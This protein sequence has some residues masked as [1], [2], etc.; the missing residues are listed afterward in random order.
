MKK[1]MCLFYLL[2]SINSLYAI[3]VAI[4]DAENAVYFTLDSNWVEAL[5][6]NQVAIVK[7]TQSFTN[8][9]T[10]EH[11]SIYAFP[12]PEGASAT[13]LRW[14]YNNQWNQATINPIPDTGQGMPSNPNSNLVAYL[15]ET[16]LYFNIPDTVA[17]DSTIIV[18]LTYVELL[19]Y[20]WGNVDLIIPN[21]YQLIQTGQV[22]LQ[23][24]DFQLNSLRYIDSLKLLSNHP[25]SSLVNNGYYASLFS[26][27]TEQPANEDYH[28]QYTLNLDSLGLFA[29]STYLPD[30]LVPDTFGGGFF[31]FVAEPAP[32][33]DVINKV[34]TLMIDRSGSMAGNKIVQARDA[35]SFIVNNLNPGDR[36][37][38]IS[39]ASDVTCFSDSHVEYDTQTCSA[40]LSYI[41]GLV[42][43]GLTNISGAFEIAVPQ[44]NAAGDSTA[45]III[46]FTDG[47]PTT[48]ITN[49]AQLIT[50][51]HDLIQQTGNTICLFTFGIGS[52]VNTQLL[53]QLAIQNNGLSQF[54]G[55]ESLFVV[56]SE[57]YL[58]IRNPVI[59]NTNI[60]FS[61][62]YI[63]EVYPDPL[64][65]L[66]KGSQMIVTG[67]Y[68]EAIET[69]ISLT[70]T[71][72]GDSVNYNYSVLF[73]D[74]ANTEY[75]F[76][77]KIWAKQ[78]IEHLL[79]E[80]YGMDTLSAPA[81]AIKAEIIW[82]SVNYGVICPWTQF[83]PNEISEEEV[84]VSYPENLSKPYEIIGCRYPQSGG[85]I[86]IR[87]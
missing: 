17:I 54:V 84:D 25:I 68:L 7:T 29:L 28:I 41:A 79:V 12:L 24:L 65:N 15:G 33:C 52:D 62:S 45:N 34:F 31:L 70:G 60:S 9:L 63:N 32:S 64:P 53:T 59:M 49:I 30:S 76:L 73:S 19:P 6:E 23:Q 69:V 8:N 48:G 58:K 61:N 1:V 35:A 40:A 78:K 16:P 56:I 22:L 81:Q 86:I 10:N 87:F 42:A 39:F 36:F 13:G 26:Q 21:D 27:I 50:Y 2:L 11:V 85:G 37:N 67:R 5:V 55:S 57:F 3:G 75:Q 74:S 71:A 14:F 83:G 51:V 77:T 46:F 18:E 82:L 20:S 80:Y 72:F 47:N 38:I 43:S 66:Y 44:F 4:V